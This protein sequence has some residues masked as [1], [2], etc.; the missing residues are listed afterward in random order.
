ML[1]SLDFLDIAGQ[2]VR[3]PC[4]L[5]S[6]SFQPQ[7]SLSKQPQICSDLKFQ[8]I[9]LGSGSFQLLN[10]RLSANTEIKHAVSYAVTYVSQTCRLLSCCASQQMR[11]LTFLANDDSVSGLVT[12]YD[13][14]SHQVKWCSNQSMPW[15]CKELPAQVWPNR[16]Q[17]GIVCR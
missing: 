8:T 14:P 10:I 4:S 13:I 15:Q 1:G 2:E 12:L 16:I 17:V 3:Y 5:F 6:S 11:P 9:Q 7:S